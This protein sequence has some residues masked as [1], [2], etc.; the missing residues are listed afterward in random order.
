MVAGQVDVICRVMVCGYV[1][2]CVMLPAG[3]GLLHGLRRRAV[4][5]V[6]INFLL[7]VGLHG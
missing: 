2:G 7:A 3:L 6:R 1:I 4:K 5:V